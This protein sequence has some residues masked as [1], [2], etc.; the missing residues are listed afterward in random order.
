MDVDGPTSQFREYCIT[1]SCLFV[2]GWGW[3]RIRIPFTLHHKDSVKNE[4]NVRRQL[5]KAYLTNEN[6]LAHQ[7]L[8]TCFLLQ[9]IREQ[10]IESHLIIP[11]C[12][13]SMR[14]MSDN[15]HFF[16]V[17]DFVFVLSCF[18]YDACRILYVMLLVEKETFPSERDAVTKIIIEREEQKALLSNQH[19]INNIVILI[20]GLS[21]L[22]KRFLYP[23][24]SSS[25]IFTS[26]V[27]LGSWLLERRESGTKN[28]ERLLMVRLFYIS[29]KKRYIHYQ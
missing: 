5:S 7:Q 17:E 24:Y 20:A 1:G 11:Y 23:C 21:T 25:L 15:K 29:W 14:W 22:V 16:L 19:H 6:N 12:P 10:R 3:E 26:S 9:R 13:L 8:C 27:C 18:V 28:K 2:G 4:N